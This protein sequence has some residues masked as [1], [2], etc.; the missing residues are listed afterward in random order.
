MLAVCVF[1]TNCNSKK[2]FTING[3]DYYTKKECLKDTFWTES[4]YRYGYSF[5]GR[6]EYSFGQINKRKCLEF[7]IDTLV[8]K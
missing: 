3:I 2:E 8:C 6:F 5:R 7:K 4:G 1:L